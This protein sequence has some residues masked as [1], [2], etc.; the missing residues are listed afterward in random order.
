MTK[1]FRLFLTVSQSIT[2]RTSITSKVTRN[3]KKI[4]AIPPEAAPFNDDIVNLERKSQS[5]ISILS[6]IKKK[7]CIVMDILEFALKQEREIEQ[8]YRSM[9]DKA[10]NSGIR[11]ILEMLAVNEQHHESII[12]QM[13]QSVPIQERQAN[14]IQEADNILSKLKES[15]EYFGLTQDDLVLYEQARDI[16][17]QKEQTYLELAARSVSVT[18][19]QIFEELA[20]E[21]H[22]HYMLMDSLCDLLGRS[23]W[24]LE[25]GEFSHIEDYVE[26]TF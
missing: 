16:E 8:H 19:R 20:E 17:Y 7:G 26:G 9:A 25:D 12:E 18:Q 4:S 24:Y 3:Y 2:G 11:N 1:A 22:K 10:P 13:M 21:E 6:K 14:F 5:V 15:D 23:Q